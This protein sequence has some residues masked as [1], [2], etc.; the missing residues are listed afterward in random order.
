MTFFKKEL[1]LVEGELSVL[2]EIFTERDDTQQDDEKRGYHWS[3]AMTTT[4]RITF[5]RHELRFNATECGVT[6]EAT[7]NTPLR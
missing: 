7:L 5:Q 1:T 2:K 4:A 6:Q 3:P